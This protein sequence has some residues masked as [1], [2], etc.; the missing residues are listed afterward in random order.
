M[1][2]TC[3]QLS[4]CLL[5][6]LM[7]LVQQAAAQD[8]NTVSG[9]VGVHSSSTSIP[10]VYREGFDE[11]EDWGEGYVVPGTPMTDVTLSVNWT[12]PIARRWVGSVEFSAARRVP[13]TTIELR[14][15]P[16]KFL[17]LGL[18]LR[19][20]PVHR[21]YETF[22]QDR[23]GELPF[24]YYGTLRAKFG[25][26]IQAGNR[27][28]ITPA[29]GPSFW[30][31]FNRNAVSKDDYEFGPE[32]SNQLPTIFPDGRVREFVAN[33]FGV[34][35]RADL[36]ARYQVAT[37]LNVI[38]RGGYDYDL[39]PFQKSNSEDGIW[40]P[41]KWRALSFDIGVGFDI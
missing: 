37:N 34:G 6:T 20:L 19:G 27:L 13:P 22:D 30:I 21:R 15:Y 23:F 2:L 36:S 16:S 17:G 12:S 4:S 32:I 11:V 29:C 9:F 7:S 18:S 41:S 35:L 38:L 40:K 26:V 28:S 31:L 5:V 33:R 25:Y 3:W 39:T 14:T 24:F 8:S 10:G 1:S